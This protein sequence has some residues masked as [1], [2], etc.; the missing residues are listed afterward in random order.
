M[1]FAPTVLSILLALCN[2][3]LAQSG[4]VV[5]AVDPHRGI[6]G[7]IGEHVAPLLLKFRNARVNFL[8]AGHLLIGKQCAGAHKALVDLLKQLLVLAF[9]GGVFVI[10]DI[11]DALEEFLVE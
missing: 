2:V 8:H 5:L 9:Q 4:Q 3:G 6:V 7:R 1:G 11:F 10:V